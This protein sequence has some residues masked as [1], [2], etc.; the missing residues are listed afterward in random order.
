[1]RCIPTWGQK[2]HWLPNKKDPM[3][4]QGGLLGCRSC[5]EY[6]RIC[7][8]GIAMLLH[9]VW[10]RD[11]VSDAQMQNL[12]FCQPH[13]LL[14]RG[15]NLCQKLFLLLSVFTKTLSLGYHERE[16][17][18][19]QEILLGSIN[20]AEKRGSLEYAIKTVS[21]TILVTHSDGSSL[22]NEQHV[23]LSCWFW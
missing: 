16:I 3:S 12:V 14:F 8:Q 22:Q 20:S 10:V 18:F 13:C 17:L 4:F 1:M 5:T 7:R 2:E 21:A 6:I 19:R 23:W 15:R 11:C 9:G